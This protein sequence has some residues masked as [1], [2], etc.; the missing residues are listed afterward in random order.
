M[1]KV[2]L[3]F[4]ILNYTIWNNLSVLTLVLLSRARHARIRM[5]VSFNILL[6]SV[7]SKN[8][9]FSIPPLSIIFLAPASSLANT[10]KL[11]AACSKN[12]TKQIRIRMTWCFCFKK[13]LNN[14]IATLIYIPVPS[15]Q[16]PLSYLKMLFQ[17]SD[18]LDFQLT[19]VCPSMTSVVVDKQVSRCFN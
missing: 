19:S 14:K 5:A 4:P 1:L 2:K 8:D 18:S 16:D 11:F 10:I 3:L 7:S 17:T 6:F 13:S 12:K 9:I 15:F